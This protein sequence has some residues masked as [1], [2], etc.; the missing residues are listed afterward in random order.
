M[1]WIASGADVNQQDLNGWTA[2]C[3]AAGKGDIAIVRAPAMIAIAAGQMDAA[4]LL[5]ELEAGRPRHPPEPERQ[6]CAAFHMRE[7]R[8]FPD[9][10]ESDADRPSDNSIAYLHQ[11]FHVTRTIWPRRR[12]SSTMTVTNGG[13]FAGRL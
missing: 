1:E 2:L 3:W 7:L 8:E 9:W 12:S 10:Q 4:R 13:D 6:C 11:D 5:L